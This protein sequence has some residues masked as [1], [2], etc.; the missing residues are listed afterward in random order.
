VTFA[1]DK[2][3]GEWSVLKLKFLQSYLTSY[4][5]ATKRAK[6]KY[7]IDC[8]AGDTE[9]IHKSTKQLVEGS[10]K[11]VL[12]IDKSFDAYYFIEMDPQRIQ[13]LE[14]VRDIYPYKNINI[15]QGD[16]NEKLPNILENIEKKSPTFIFFD[17]DGVHI[18]WETL[19]KA[20][21]WRTEFLINFPFNMSIK[22]NLPTDIS[23]LKPSF[24]TT[25]TEFYGTDEW[26]N[27]YSSA[28]IPQSRKNNMLISLYVNNL[29]TLG[30][31]YVIISPPFCN[32][33]GAILYYLIFAGNNPVG[34]K[35]M[36]HVFNKQF[37]PQ[38]TL[39]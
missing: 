21:Q 32:Q 27:I 31:K 37:N 39:F 8:F 22:R 38:G 36:G 13:Q 24:K 26:Y 19:I 4:L 15:Y 23:K 6:H 35:I 29:K 34:E 14:K 20:S 3:V 9:Y 1:D 2:E 16:C 11:I 12:N 18:K 5:V 7:Y 10:S 28:S 17:T 25:L 33:T 30:F